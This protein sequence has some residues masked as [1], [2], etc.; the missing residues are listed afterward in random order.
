MS[1]KLLKP[2]FIDI[3]IISAKEKTVHCIVYPHLHY[4]LNSHSLGRE[5]GKDRKKLNWHK[6][7]QF[8]I[9]IQTIISMNSNSFDFQEKS[10]KGKF[11]L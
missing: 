8:S 11:L 10:I 9:S 1:K 2:K 7:I 6:T 3:F 4:N 5:K